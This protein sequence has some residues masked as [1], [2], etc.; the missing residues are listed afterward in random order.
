MTAS[1][2]PAI[3][4]R[5]LIVIITV[6]SV[7]RIEAVSGK[8][9]IRACSIPSGLSD[10]NSGARY[11]VEKLVFLLEWNGMGLQVIHSKSFYRS[12]KLHIAWGNY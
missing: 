8:M 10:L 6:L 9:T 11:L 2:A 5:D 1:K 3:S 4:L 7:F 12:Y